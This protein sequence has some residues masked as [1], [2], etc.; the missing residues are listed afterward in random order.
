MKSDLF[1]TQRKLFYNRTLYQRV[2]PNPEQILRTYYGQHWKSPPAEKDRKP[3]GG[4][5]RK[6]CPYGPQETFEDKKI[7]MQT[8]K[9]LNLEKYQP[10][11]TIGYKTRNQCENKNQISTC[12]KV[13]V[14]VVSNQPPIDHNQIETS[15]H[16]A[17]CLFFQCEKNA[18][19]CD[20]SNPTNYNGDKPPCCVHILR[21]IA[22]EFDAEMCRIGV[23]YIATF[24]TLLGLIRSDRIIPWTGDMDYIIPSK[25]AANAM[26]HLWDAKRTGL[27]H[28]YQDINRMCITR[29]FANGELLK[30]NI[31]A[32]NPKQ[33]IRGQICGDNGNTL[34]DCGFP[35]VDF[36]VGRDHPVYKG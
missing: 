3:H 8:C 4:G 11:K 24:G 30:W 27:R 25:A 33:K 19:L 1:P 5:R 7:D 12:K 9:H 31:S 32:P 14:K 15:I 34:W 20:N 16:K 28:V 26:V 6:A 10:A 21:D 23:D 17:G 29:D 18:T 35:Y 36:Y 13:Q 22:R 2:P